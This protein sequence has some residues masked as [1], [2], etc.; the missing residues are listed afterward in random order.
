MIGI[1]IIDLSDPQL[2]KR[3]ERTFRLIEH[4]ADRY[5]VHDLAFWLLWTAKEAI[6][7]CQRQ[8]ITFS[9][10][11][12]PV[13]IKEKQAHVYTFQSGIILG[14]TLINP[15]LILSICGNQSLPEFRVF[16]HKQAATKEFVRVKIE[17]ELMKDQ[18]LGADE[19]GLPI[20]QPEQKTLSI[21]HHH[22]YAAFAV[23][24]ETFQ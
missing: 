12:I 16:Y 6:F 20:I 8:P 10:S 3:T 13:Q 1:D 24:S 14:Q 11:Q 2:K 22:R 9:P 7:K 5:P 18:Y 23:E 17:Q 4:S 15:Q 21:S 19:L